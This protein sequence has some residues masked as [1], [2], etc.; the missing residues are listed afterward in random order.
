MSSPTRI[1][2]SSA[3]LSQNRAHRRPGAGGGAGVLSIGG[4]RPTISSVKLLLENLPAS[5]QDQHE[6]L[7]KC[8]EAMDRALPLTA[9]Y[10]FGNLRTRAITTGD[11]RALWSS[12]QMARVRAAGGAG[13]GQ[14][15]RE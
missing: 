12:V 13:L 15:S 7:A 9:V 1:G 3:H 14:D 5:L 8:L 2:G 4:E 6:T 10:L 11:L